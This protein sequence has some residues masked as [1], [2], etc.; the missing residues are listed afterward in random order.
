MLMDIGSQDMLIQKAGWVWL[1]A[2]AVV[3]KSYVIPAQ[4]GIHSAL[5][6]GDAEWI[7]ACA[8]M[9]NI[10]RLSKI[11]VMLERQFSWAR[12][13]SRELRPV[14]S[15]IRLSRLLQLGRSGSICRFCRWLLRY[16]FLCS[17]FGRAFGLAGLACF[18]F[19]QIHG[20]F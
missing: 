20:L 11:L 14:E 9:T 2:M 18:R 6:N 12:H 5:A 8:G 7:P 4:A 1:L 3:E 19:E 17:C 16:G 13:R 15:A 10:E